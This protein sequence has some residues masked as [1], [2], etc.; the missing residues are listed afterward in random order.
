MINIESINSFLHSDTCLVKLSMLYGQ[1]ERILHA[2]S[3]RYGALVERFASLFPQHT[4]I[5]FF[6][7][8]G[9]VEIGGN[10]TDHQ[11]GRVLTASIHLD[12]LAVVAANGS[13]I[14]RIHSEG[15][16][17]MEVDL[18]SLTV[19]ESECG[20]AAALIRGCSFKMQQLG[21]QVGGFDAAI[22]SDVLPGSGLSSSAALEILFCAIIDGLFNAGNLSPVERA[23]IGQ[24]AENK[25]FGKPCG[26]L[27]QMGSSFGGLVAIDFEKEEPAIETLAFDFTAHGYA[28]AIIN[29]GGDHGDLTDHYAAIPT[30]MKQVAAFFGCQHLRKVPQEQFEKAIADLRKHLKDRPVLRA[31][32]F[33]DE[34]AR[35]PMQVQALKECNLQHFF[36]L[37]QASGESSIKLLQNIH[38]DVYEQPLSLALALSQRMLEGNGAWRVH[39]GG[40]AGTILAFVPLSMVDTYTN[41]M[42]EVFGKN[43]C[44]HIN[45][46]PVGAYELSM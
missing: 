30:E 36:E 39:G 22:T 10:H 21:Y 14:V 42:N 7:S 3:M 41:Q 8:P 25:Y 29:T 20:T 12:T 16:A 34:N 32:H 4:A 19:Q 37:I 40:F 5:R 35:V 2:Q 18:S 43:A 24:F 26:L 17:P 27:D 38:A 45:V 23:K 31:M 28:M 1:E 46:R 13:H 9:R 11:L 44:V 15:F 33:F 6:S